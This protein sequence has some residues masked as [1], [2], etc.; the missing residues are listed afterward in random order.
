MYRIFFKLIFYFIILLVIAIIYLSTFGIKTSKFNDQIKEIIQNFDERINLELENV[1]LKLDLSNLTV[2]IN[3]ENPILYIE[4]SSININDSCV[5]HG[6]PDLPDFLLS[7][8]GRRKS[9]N[10]EMVHVL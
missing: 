6:C 3:T 5:E 7:D 10:L 1:Y 2:N 8:L 9:Q 4:D